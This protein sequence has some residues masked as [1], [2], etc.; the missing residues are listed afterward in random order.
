MVVSHVHPSSEE[1]S[2]LLSEAL[3]PGLLDSS[4]SGEA[5]WTLDI[6]C[7]EDEEWSGDDESEGEGKGD[8]EDG[9]NEAEGGPSVYM[10]RK[11]SAC[12]FRLDRYRASECRG[13]VLCIFAP[14]DA[15]WK[16]S[17]GWTDQGQA[18]GFP[19]QSDPAIC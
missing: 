13:H 4:S 3:V 14:A 18:L 1:C 10:A 9:E 6:H 19:N 7:S 5:L 2:E 12:C 16:K 11:V 15:R 17:L 8:G